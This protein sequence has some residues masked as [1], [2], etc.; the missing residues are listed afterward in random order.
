VVSYSSNK[1]PLLYY[2][3]YDPS[4]NRVSAC[5]GI[6]ISQIDTTHARLIKSQLEPVPPSNPSNLAADANLVRAGGRRAVFGSWP[7]RARDA[8]YVIAHVR[9]TNN[10]TGRE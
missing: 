10:A 6:A 1:T 9:T 4:Q 8:A 3:R 2:N 5:S 7:V